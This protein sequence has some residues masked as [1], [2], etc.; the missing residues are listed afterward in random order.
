VIGIRAAVAVIQ[1]MI[2]VMFRL[3]KMSD[4][5]QIS[6]IRRRVLAVVHQ[7]LLVVSAPM[8]CD[9]EIVL[10]RVLVKVP[11]TWAIQLND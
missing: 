7:M 10:Q 1:D 3:L 6:T 11:P 4:H 8:Y 5:Y 9:V 2:R